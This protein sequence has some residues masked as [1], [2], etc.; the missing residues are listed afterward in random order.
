MAR[1]HTE[2]IGLEAQQRLG[3]AVLTVALAL[4]AAGIT[5]CP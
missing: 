5:D 3:D 4:Y 2:A 1:Q